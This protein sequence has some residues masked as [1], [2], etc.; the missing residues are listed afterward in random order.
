MQ[1]GRPARADFPTTRWTIL[2]D[3]KNRDGTA[4]QVALEELC[5]LYHYPLY[6]Y[7]RRRELSHHD[8]EDI[9]HDFLCR[10]IR[11]RSY[12]GLDKEKGRL[13]GFL[14]HALSRYTGTWLRQKTKLQRAGRAEKSFLPTDVARRYEEE[15]FSHEDTPDR[16]FD[17]KWAQTLMS[18]A[19]ESLERRHVERGKLREFAVMRPMLTNSGSLKGLDVSAMARELE[20]SIKALRVAASRMLD[21]FGWEV[22][23]ELRRTI[24]D[25]DC[26]DAELE[27]LLRAVS[28]E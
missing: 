4:S 15:D 21:E 26:M 20:I 23:D 14:A 27:H 1:C 12:D 17:R 8:A 19:L 28:R 24:G 22:Q 6:C 11:L 5:R 18:R 3:I 7:L 25:P 9:L 13:R 16:I 2:D 10:F